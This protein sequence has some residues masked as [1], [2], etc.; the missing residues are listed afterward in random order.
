MNEQVSA[1]AVLAW[2]EGLPAGFEFRRQ[3][4]PTICDCLVGRYLN[5]RA[6]PGLRWAVGY[7]T[8]TL[9]DPETGERAGPMSLDAPT[10]QLIIRFDQIAGDRTITAGEL[11]SA[12]A[13]EETG[14]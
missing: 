2:L 14:E 9:T 7:S 3:G 4:I 1:D 8:A 13:E 12:L 10:Q 6:E 5:E 11:R